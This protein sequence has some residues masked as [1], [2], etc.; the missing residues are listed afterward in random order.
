[1]KQNVKIPGVTGITHCRALERFRGQ[2]DFKTNQLCQTQHGCT[3]P[4]IQQSYD[5]LNAHI[6][7]RYLEALGQLQPLYQEVFASLK[8]LQLLDL[9]AAAVPA[10]MGEES[11]RQAAA[12]QEAL[13]QGA[14]RRNE[15]LLRMAQVRVDIAVIDEQ[16]IH[17]LEKA[18]AIQKAKVS[19]YWEGIL[20]QAKDSKLPPF[21][22]IPPRQL[23]GE[24]AYRQLKQN[25]DQCMDNILGR[26][27][28]E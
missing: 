22:G 6:N 14:K 23:P 10:G 8:E 17:C 21:P 11:L 7:A 9:P 25:V 13:R 3:T 12:R 18:A 2:R 16:L 5:C 27:E 28:K 15:I 26:K 1:M 20:K 24:E 19:A 4:R